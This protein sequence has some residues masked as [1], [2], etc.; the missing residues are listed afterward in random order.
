LHTN[1]QLFQKKT[2]KENDAC[3]F[4]DG[5]PKFLHA[6]QTAFLEQHINMQVKHQYLWTT[7]LEL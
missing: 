7:T 3:V 2:F 5:G 4:Y 6:L 1:L